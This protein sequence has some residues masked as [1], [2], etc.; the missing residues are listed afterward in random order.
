VGAAVVA[1]GVAAVLGY[2]I[3]SIDAA[4][5]AA[6]AAAVA[7]GGLLA[8]LTDS[9]M[10]FGLEHGGRLA[11]VWTSLVSHYRLRFSKRA[12]DARGWRPMPQPEH[13]VSV[14]EF[15]SVL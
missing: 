12:F 1:C 2:A 11:G 14:R 6:R 4:A 15:S 10:P 7:A 9:L 8:M 5:T 13:A 3:V